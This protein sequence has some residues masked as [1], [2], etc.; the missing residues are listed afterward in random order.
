M[1]TKTKKRGKKFGSYEAEFPLLITGPAPTYREYNPR[2]D[3]AMA[4]ALDRAKRDQPELL[5]LSS[6]VPAY[7]NQV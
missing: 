1:T 4:A 2:A 6:D 5:S 7:G 3:R